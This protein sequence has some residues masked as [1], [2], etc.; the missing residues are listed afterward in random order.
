MS[1]KEVTEM[2]RKID[3]GILLAQTRLMKR[4]KHDNISLVVARNG[5]VVEIKPEEL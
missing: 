3:E 2:Q 4:A 1:E 5:K